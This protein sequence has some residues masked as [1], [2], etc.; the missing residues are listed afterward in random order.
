MSTLRTWLDDAWNR[1]DSAPR[2]LA[3]ELLALAPTLPDDADGAEAVRL[4]RHTLL[5]HLADTAALQHWLGLLPAGAQLDVQKERTAW[6]LTAL[7]SAAA[8]AAS[9]APFTHPAHP[10]LADAVA[11]GLLGDVAQALIQRGDVP[12][13]RRCLLALEDTA[14]AHADTAARRAF[15][16]SAHNVALA[17]RTGPREPARDALMIDMADLERRAWARAGG[18]MEVERADYHLALCHAVLGHG[19]QAVAHASACLQACEAHA[20]DA[21]ERFFGHECAVHAAL[22]AGDQAAASAHRARMVA[23]LEDVTDAGM[24]TWCAQTLAST[25]QA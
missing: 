17:L 22:A 6:A 23:L 13:A 19:A 1:H 14:A 15:A 25:P 7:D 12:A 8:Q 21:V 2:A 11:W 9:A 4:A 10:A 16:A 18:W 24:K 3:D 5:A 20:A